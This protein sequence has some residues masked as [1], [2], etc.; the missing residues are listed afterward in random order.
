MIVSVIM[1]TCAVLTFE[2]GM[3]AILVDAW[4]SDARR[5]AVGLLDYFAP[6]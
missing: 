4:Y 2:R 3:T 1:L 5:V 6:L